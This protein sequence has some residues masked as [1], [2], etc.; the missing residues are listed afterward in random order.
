MDVGK[1]YFHDREENSENDKTRLS[2]KKRRKIAR[3]SLVAI[4]YTSTIGN[5]MSLHEHSRREFIATV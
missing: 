1:S 3:G 2:K 5:D 4:T